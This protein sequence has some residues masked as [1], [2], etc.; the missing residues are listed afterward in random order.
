[1]GEPRNVNSLFAE[2]RGERLILLHDD[3]TLL[4]GTISTL[5]STFDL[6]PNVIASFGL[7]EI[8]SH[9]GELC[10]EQTE[11]FNSFFHRVPAAGGVVTDPLLSALRRQF[12]ND[13]FLLVSDAARA[14]GYRTVEDIGRAGDTDFGIR[15]AREYPHSSFAFIPRVTARYRLT[16]GSSRTRPGI[17]WKLHEELGC[18]DGLTFEQAKARDKL[19]QDIQVHAMLDNAMNGNRRKA[20]QIFRSHSYRRRS[21]LPESFYHCAVIIAPAIQR[22]R[23]AMRLLRHQS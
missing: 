15:L 4:P 17:C 10:R 14:V 6:H 11:E 7:Q 19:M 13:G 2:A 8:M 22:L 1:L 18:M 5:A 16:D 23:D 21:T 12:P 3:D 9:D 20:F